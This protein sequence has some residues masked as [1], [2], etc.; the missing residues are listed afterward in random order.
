MKMESAA[1]VRPLTLTTTNAFRYTPLCRTVHVVPWLG[2]WLP[3]GLASL[4]NCVRIAFFVPSSINN[5][6]FH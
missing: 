6:V 2:L 5:M 3:V 1:F 4:C